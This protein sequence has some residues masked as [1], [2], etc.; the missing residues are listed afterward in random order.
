MMTAPTVE[1]VQ[2]VSCG[3]QK[4]NEGPHP[5]AYQ[6]TFEL[7]NLLSHA[8]VPDLS[9]SLSTPEVV[10]VLCGLLRLSCRAQHH[11]L[12]KQKH[13]LICN[14]TAFIQTVSI[15]GLGMENVL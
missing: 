3:V 15:L 4:Q 7:W 11:Q 12:I 9:K 5:P 13:R 14:F 1:E 2:P 10:H 8:V 6:E